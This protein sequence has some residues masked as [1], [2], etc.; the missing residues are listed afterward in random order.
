MSEMRRLLCLLLIASLLVTAFGCVNRVNEENNTE[1]STTTSGQEVDPA[2]TSDSEKEEP[3]PVDSD[4]AEDDQ[5]DTKDRS[6]DD[7]DDDDEGEKDSV[8]VN[9]FA[10]AVSGLFFD[11]SGKDVIRTVNIEYT[12]LLSFITT[13]SLEAE[14]SKSAIVVSS[15]ADNELGN[16]MILQ[17]SQNGSY[18]E[19]IILGDK[20]YHAFT[21]EEQTVKEFTVTDSEESALPLGDITPSVDSDMIYS[22]ISTA[23]D[24][25]SY[26][27]GTMAVEKDDNGAVQKIIIGDI[28]SGFINSYISILVSTV[29]ELLN[30]TDALDDQYGELFGYL[31][32]AINDDAIDYDITVEIIPDELGHFKHMDVS[33]SLNIEISTGVF[34]ASVT[35]IKLTA[36]VDYDFDSEVQVIAPADSDDYI[37]VPYDEFIAGLIP[38][39]FPETE[40]E[41]G[42]PEAVDEII[43]DN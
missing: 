17:I 38:I 15:D 34:K 16:A 2:V 19:Y 18:S 40:T 42:I 39:D 13:G 25:L 43:P 10:E 6:D 4:D 36:G 30:E 14:S 8:D 29:S 31:V 1:E 21:D 5:D 28:N 23:G 11:Y 26:A 41:E 33:L 7:S 3:D 35:V 24:D 22:L 20:I 12:S 32:S 27:I 37:E 9:E